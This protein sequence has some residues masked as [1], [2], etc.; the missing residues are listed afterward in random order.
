MLTGVA[1]RDLGVQVL[2][3]R[4]PH[5]LIVAPMA[6]Q[7]LAHPE[8]EIE[9]A[10]GAAQAEAIMCLSTLA[11]TG[12]GEVAQAVP[13]APRWFQ[14][15][16]FR[17]RGITRELIAQ[18]AD[19]GYEALVV[20]VDLPILGVRERELRTGVNAAASAVAGARAA[21]ASGNLTPADF[22]G[23]LDPAFAGT[24]W[25]RSRR[26]ASCRCW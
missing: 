22:A 3:R 7:R 15:Y 13:G 2:G 26:T 4:R 12:A 6:F 23:L 14:V 16:V 21:G 11:T 20:T 5:P 24:T 1:E 18:A 10:R 8:G 25:R 19:H 9:M 17:D